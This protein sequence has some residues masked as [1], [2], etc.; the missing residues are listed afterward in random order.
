MNG[1]TTKRWSGFGPNLREA[2]KAYVTD[3]TDYDGMETVARS[4]VDEWGRIDI[5][6]NNAGIT[7]PM[8]RAEE[9]KRQDF[10]RV[11]DVNVKGAFYASQV[12][13]KG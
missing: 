7:G 2:A 9:V 3:I 4:V 11:I 10:D 5:L 12:F 6:V 8:A 13:G 1:R